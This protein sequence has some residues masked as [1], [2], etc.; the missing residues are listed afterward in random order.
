MIVFHPT[1]LQGLT[2][3][4]SVLL[5]IIV[6]LVT[7]KVTSPTAKALLLLGLSLIT[8]LVSAWILAVQSGNAFDLWS[9]LYTSGTV[10]IIAV[11]SHFGLWR[12]TGVSAVAARHLV[13]APT[14]PA[15]VSDISS[16]PRTND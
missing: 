1:L 13:T 7:T 10:F 15:G 2:L 6:G 8:S 11:A 12:P 3:V 9:A 14:D 4:V 5:P 16:L